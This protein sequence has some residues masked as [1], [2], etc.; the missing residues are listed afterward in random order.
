M[1][2]SCENCGKKYN[3]DESK[4]QG[5]QALGI[6]TQCNE[7]IVFSL[8]QVDFTSYNEGASEDGTKRVTDEKPDSFDVSTESFVEQREAS[9][10]ELSPKLLKKKK[11]F[12]GGI[13]SKTFV[14]FFIV[15]FIFILV[16]GYLY[17]SWLDTL[18]SHVASEKRSIVTSLIEKSVIQRAEDVADEVK[19]YL[20]TH[21]EISIE[22]L[23]YDLEFREIALQKVGKTGYTAVDHVTESGR[24]LF[25][26]GPEVVLE[27]GIRK[28]LVNEELF[29]LLQKRILENES[30][31]MKG[32]F[33][34]AEQ[35]G[36]LVTGYQTFVDGK[37]FQ[38]IAPV[39]EYPLFVHATALISEV[40]Q[41]LD[42]L[43]EKVV[44]TRIKIQKN[45]LLV[46]AAITALIAIIILFCSTSIARKLKKLT[47]ISNR[48]SKGNKDVSIDSFG[49]DELG[50]LAESIKNLQDSIQR[51]SFGKRL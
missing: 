27:H 39:A 17:L 7:K 22:Q 2:V 24:W 43:Q 1:I 19:L 35:T 32:M 11:G 41:S 28:N 40:S 31:K 38:A 33:V 50:E 48:I 21:P 44:V 13:G 36:R 8:P 4:I 14:L 3:V 34:Q 46:L 6:C 51:P 10:P 16:S 15:P 29:H 42:K 5:N 20:D 23:G 37:R 12:G 18:S 47:E 45:V 25:V 26:A 9:D 30:K 49:N